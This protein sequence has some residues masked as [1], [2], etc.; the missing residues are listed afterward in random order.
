MEE[1]KCKAVLIQT[2]RPAWSWG[3]QNL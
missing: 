1:S 2:L 3:S